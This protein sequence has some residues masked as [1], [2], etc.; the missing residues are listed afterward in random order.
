MKTNADYSVHYKPSTM[1]Y[2]VITVPKGTRVTH[3]TA[4]GIDKK[5]HFVDDFSW[6]KPLE[7]GKP[8]S[9]LIHDL[10][11]HGIN[12]PKEFIEYDKP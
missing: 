1:D 10:T 11:Y 3:M 9:L 5:Y 7:D 6:V 2:G 8:N 12:V 4:T